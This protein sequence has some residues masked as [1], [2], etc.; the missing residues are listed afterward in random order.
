MRCQVDVGDFLVKHFSAKFRL[1]EEVQAED[2][3]GGN[4]EHG[5]YQ[6]AEERAEGEQ[7]D[8]SNGCDFI[9]FIIVNETGL[10]GQKLNSVGLILVRGRTG[11]FVSGERL[12]VT[13]VVHSEKWCLLIVSAGRV[14]VVVVS[15]R[16]QVIHVHRLDGC[17]DL[18]QSLRSF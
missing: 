4:D 18:K 9:F 13:R 7:A 16:G 15:V 2:T 3:N 10:V 12:Q 1:P 6:V 8:V 17:S 5:Y 14:G 11:G